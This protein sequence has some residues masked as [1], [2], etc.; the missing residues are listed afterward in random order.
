MTAAL[1][2]LG[3]VYVFAICYCLGQSMLGNLARYLSL[4]EKVFLSFVVGCIPF[5]TYVLVLCVLNFVYLWTLLVPLPVA[6][7]LWRRRWIGN[8]ETVQRA[9][10]GKIWIALF[11]IPCI[12]FGARYFLNAL[13]PEHSP[14][15]IIYHVALISRFF[16]N[17]GFRGMPKNIYAG[18]VSGV[19]M[20]YLPAFAIGRHSA[21]AM[22]HLI[23]LFLLPIGM[24]SLA[25]RYG[26]PNSGLIAAL[27]FFLAP[28]V[29]VDGSSAYNDVA[30]AAIL[31]GS[32]YLLLIWNETFDRRA[33]ALTAALA[34]FAF[35][36]KYTTASFLLFV[37][38]AVC[39][40]SYRARRRI[41]GNSAVFLGCAAIAILPWLLRNF[42]QFHNP[43]FPFYSNWFESPY[44]YS[45]VEDN[46]R[47]SLAHMNDVKWSEIPV[48]AMWG[49]RLIGVLG[50]VFVIAPIGLLA[51]RSKLGRFALAAIPFFVLAYLGNIGTRF[52]IPMLPF[53][54]VAIGIG[55]T[56]I[57][58]IG[59]PL[60]IVF[61]TAHSF[62]AWP[63]NI[64]SWAPKDY[65]HLDPVT[66]REALRITPESE[67]LTK[68]Y[69]EFEISLALDKHVPP[70][71][72]VFAVGMDGSA[73]H[74]RD[75]VGIWQSALGKRAWD[76]YL[77]L[78]LPEGSK[79]WRTVWKLPETKTRGIRIVT[80]KSFPD[81]WRISELRFYSNDKEIPRSAKWRLRSSNNQSELPYALDGGTSSWWT[82][83]RA[84]RPGQWV[85]VDFQNEQVVGEVVVERSIDRRWFELAVQT[86]AAGTWRESKAAG[87]SKDFQLLQS[88]RRSSTEAMKRLGLRWIVAEEDAFGAKDLREKPQQWGITQVAAGGRYRLWRL[89]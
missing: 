66:W 55:L 10:P 82:S 30:V 7:L 62:L 78:L 19:E 4:P 28:V 6:A 67:F 46:F 13:A 48:Q 74:H 44:F 57:P 88:A 61:L 16:E 42:F 73:Y 71:D 40:A 68:R 20:V 52:L 21:P 69:G 41:A 31:F 24:V 34:G 85:E 89:D 22:T 77:Q 80:R 45:Y 60:A 12:I 54:C 53:L 50:P 2:V 70:G 65:W 26:H 35:V 9:L 84:T 87:E 14:D 47:D 36:C 33:L 64:P 83:G 51:F 63:A 39:V 59:A 38:L 58:F 75:I 29:A 5:S 17:H 27:L 25:S 23:F 86:N 1:V 32:F 49:G 37:L 11:L 18:L 15:G 56:T 76:I 72:K 8:G 79:Y 3:A 81:D 43:V